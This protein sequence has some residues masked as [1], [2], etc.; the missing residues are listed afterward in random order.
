MPVP[1]PDVDRMR[2]IYAIDVVDSGVVVLEESD[3]RLLD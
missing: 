3:A 2:M 1:L